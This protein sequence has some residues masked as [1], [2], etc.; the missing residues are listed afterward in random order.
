MSA[1]GSIFTGYGLFQ[2]TVLHKE[3]FFVVLSTG[4]GFSLHYAT[5]GVAHYMLAIKYNG[6]AVNVPRMLK[7]KSAEPV[8]RC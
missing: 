3:S 7:G 8:T 6:M 2:M 1:V 4:L 5:F